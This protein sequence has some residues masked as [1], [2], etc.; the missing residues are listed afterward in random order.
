MTEDKIDFGVVVENYGHL[1]INQLEAFRY[2]VLTEDKRFL[3][4]FPVLETARFFVASLAIMFDF[5]RIK[6]GNWVRIKHDDVWTEAMI[7]D[8]S[9]HYTQDWMPYIQLKIDHPLNIVN[10]SEA[11]AKG[12]IELVEEKNDGKTID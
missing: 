12:L 5:D 3:G 8:S 10:Y 9:V 2:F 6:A 4:E 7:K 11:L 1:T